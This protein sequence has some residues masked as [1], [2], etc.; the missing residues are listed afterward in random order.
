[1]QKFLETLHPLER[2]IL[3][4]LKDN[5]SL[6]DLIKLSHL[7]E[8]EV[9]RAL[10]WLEN[11]EILK[12]EIEEKELISLDENGYIYV[13]N[14]LPERQLL[15]ALSYLSKFNELKENTQLSHEE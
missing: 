8:V 3:P 2:T 11:K 4:C 7:S 12:I 9:M 10:Q 13:K 14:G 5:V 1:M 6:S 15:N